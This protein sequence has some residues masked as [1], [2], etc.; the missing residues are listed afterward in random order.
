MKIKQWSD[1]KD[2]ENG[3]GLKVE[4]RTL[5]GYDKYCEIGIKDT[6][7]PSYLP[8]NLGEYRK[9]QLKGVIDVLRKHG[10]DIEYEKPFK[11]TEFLKENLKPKEF[12]L[13]ET[14]LYF[15]IENGNHFLIMNEEELETLNCLYFTNKTDDG[16]IIE[17]TLYNEKVTV[18]QLNFALKELGWL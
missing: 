4:T 8:L 11:L 3:R 10:F 14:N 7:Y 12:K 15:A 18:G 9:N 6:E 2:L 13:N 5:E 1:L 17:E 16:N